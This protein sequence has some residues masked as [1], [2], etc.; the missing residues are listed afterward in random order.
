MKMH[1]EVVSGPNIEYLVIPRGNGKDI[2]FKFQ[3]VLDT[4]KMHEILKAPKPS[5]RMYPGGKI[6]EDRDDPAFK[7]QMLDFG[8]AKFN[9]MI[10]RSIEAT[11]GLEWSTVNMED[12]QTWGNWETEMQ[13]A[14]FN[15]NEIQLVQIT[16][17]AA[18]ALDQSKLDEARA[19]FLASLAVITP[20]L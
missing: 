5:E 13:A 14:G 7:A 15:A 16:A 4:K 19:R 18:N 10:L 17:A 11:E 3:A 1:G 12:P 2:V 9:Y 8:N 20:A 6:V